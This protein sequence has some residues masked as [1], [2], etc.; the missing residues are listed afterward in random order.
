TD[1]VIEYKLSSDAVWLV[2]S[3]GTSTSLSATVTGLANGSGYDFRV[4]AVNTV[5]QS[6][7]NS[8]GGTPTGGDSGNAGGGSSGSMPRI[9][10]NTTVIDENPEVVPGVPSSEPTTTPTIQKN[11]SSSGVGSGETVQPNEASATP[12]EKII[13][14]YLDFSNPVSIGEMQGTFNPGWA[15]SLI[16]LLIVGLII[17]FVFFRVY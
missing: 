8:T 7:I 11:N 9:L 14:D 13:N 17:Y 10:N 6:V 4:S 12:S 15:I 5:G 2:F 1:Y 3:D 16:L